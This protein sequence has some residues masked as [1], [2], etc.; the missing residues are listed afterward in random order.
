MHL[1]YSLVMLSFAEHCV[2]ESK[3]SKLSTASLTYN[4]GPEDLKEPFGCLP[5]ASLVIQV[6]KSACHCGGPLTFVESRLIVWFVLI[7]YCARLFCL[8]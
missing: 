8:L 6:S 7:W 2:S 3:L 5:A 4:L 1:L